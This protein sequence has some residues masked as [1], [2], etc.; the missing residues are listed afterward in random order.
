MTSTHHHNLLW[1]S[2]LKYETLSTTGHFLIYMM[3][4]I[5]L[6]MQEGKACFTCWDS[7]IT[8]LSHKH[9]N[10][11]ETE[12]FCHIQII[13]HYTWMTSHDLYCDEEM[14]DFCITYKAKGSCDCICNDGIHS[15]FTYQ[16]A[17]KKWLDN[18]N[19]LSPL[20]AR[21]MDVFDCLIEEYHQIRFDNHMCAKIT[22][23]S[24]LHAKKMI[25][26][27][28]TRTNWCGL[29]CGHTAWGHYKNAID[30]GMDILKAT[31]M[32]GYDY[33][34]E[35]SFS[36]V[37]HYATKPIHNWLDCLNSWDRRQISWHHLWRVLLMFQY[38]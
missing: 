30:A 27:G 21:C 4:K 16:T 28:V 34:H 1:N 3:V 33:L 29:Q 38:L 15:S 10:V 8:V 7:Q 22:L 13:F 31:V 14:I 6:D 24:Y 5:N 35:C 32:E 25:I 37:S 9:L 18:H 19:G 20:G 36:R 2:G 17:S 12:Y 23:S 11:E 26:D